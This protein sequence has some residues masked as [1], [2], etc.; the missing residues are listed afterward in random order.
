MTMLADDIV[1]MNDTTHTVRGR[2]KE[3]E[4]KWVIAEMEVLAEKKMTKGKPKKKS[5]C[6]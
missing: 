3:I 2:E 1:I 6:A 5:K 4:I